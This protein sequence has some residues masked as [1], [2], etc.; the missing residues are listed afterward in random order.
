MVIIVSIGVMYPKEKIILDMQ[1]LTDMNI[2]GMKINLRQ[3]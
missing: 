1:A 3:I 2:N